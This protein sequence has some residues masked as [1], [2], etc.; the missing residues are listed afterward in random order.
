MQV[1]FETKTPG[2]ENSGIFD[3]A[4]GCFPAVL[5]LRNAAVLCS[6][7]R[8][9]FILRDA[10]AVVFQKFEHAFPQIPFAGTVNDRLKLF[11]FPFRILLFQPCFERF[12][13]LVFVGQSDRYDPPGRVDV[14]FYRIA[15][16]R[17]CF[18]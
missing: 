10:H 13:F 12:I 4:A 9:D 3:P 11:L 15:P 8:C 17:C 1:F 7:F 6:L 14:N 16:F 2:H 18:Q 5:Q